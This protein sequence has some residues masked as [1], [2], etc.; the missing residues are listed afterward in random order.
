MR[1]AARALAASAVLLSSP[2][3]AQDPAAN[4]ADFEAMWS[5]LRDRYAYFGEKETSWERVREVYAPRAAAAASRDELAVVLS[6]ALGEL[7]DPRTYLV[8]D[9]GTR[10]V[11]AGADVW[12]QWQGAQAVVLRVRPGMSAEQA[13]LREGME[14]TAVGG[15]PVA[16]A[17]T[18]LL[19]ETVSPDNP[20]ARDWALATLLAGT[21]GTPRVLRARGRDRVE[22]EM[23]L[24]LPDHVTVDGAGKPA[25][26]EARV[27]EGRL[28]YL[29]VTDLS[30]EALP[31]VEAAL[32][33]VRGTRGLLLDL[34]DAPGEGSRAAAE[35]LLGRLVSAP[36]EYA[37]AVSPAGEE[38]R[39]AA[40]GGAW[41]YAGPLV[42]LVDRWTWGAAQ[43]V[44]GA[45]GT[46]G[47]ARVVGTP[48][49]A[50]HGTQGEIRLPGSGLAVRFTAEKLYR[51]DGS[52]QDEWHPAVPVTPAEITA[53][54]PN[55]I[56]LRT[57]LQT[58]RQAAGVR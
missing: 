42:V 6:R 7:Y 52:P 32:E 51:R 29:R 35:A 5:G 38:A 3:A 16:D 44:A 47:R 54:R 19:G 14:I 45:L 2:L 48:M 13:G 22:R 10:P 43:T 36:A 8:W 17:V 28:G 12:A 27:L 31:E 15:V 58:L 30:D 26:A 18:G 24:D 4:A 11:P 33:A 55:D 53:T 37:V 23:R 50:M 9:G 40:P 34:R 25:A 41:Q 20:E 21:P 49:A 46:T 1:R 57:G 39:T 56:L